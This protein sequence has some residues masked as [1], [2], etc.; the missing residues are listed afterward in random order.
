[1]YNSFVLI[2]IIKVERAWPH[3]PHTKTLSSISNE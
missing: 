3:V 1:M 2:E